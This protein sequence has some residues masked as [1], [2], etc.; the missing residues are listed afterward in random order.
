MKKAIDKIKSISSISVP[1]GKTPEEMNTTHPGVRW[2][3]ADKRIQALRAEATQSA[4]AYAK[5]RKGYKEGAF[6]WQAPK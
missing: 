5:I 1:E 2:K 6:S 4:Q 3:K